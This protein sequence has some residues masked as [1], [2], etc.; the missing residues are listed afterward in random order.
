MRPPAKSYPTCGMPTTRANRTGLN[1]FKY[2]NE[3]AFHYYNFSA[4]T[5]YNINDKWKVFGR[6]SR[7][8]TDQDQTDFTNGQDPLKLRN[9]T[10]SKRNG[11]NIAGD[12]VY[13]ISPTMT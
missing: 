12:S 6:I 4:R 13:M 2:L 3:L 7:F 11:W 9:V 10:G 5:D 8:K 1:N